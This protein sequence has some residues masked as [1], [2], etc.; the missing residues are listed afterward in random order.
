MIG[1]SSPENTAAMEVAAVEGRSLW[2]DARARLFRN[3]A[4]VVSMIVLSIF[5]LV[6]IFGPFFWPH[7]YE[8]IYTDRVS[9]APTFEHWHILGT[10]TLGRDQ[11][12][13]LLLGFRISL[14]VGVLATLVS[15]VIGVTWGAIAGYFGGRIDQAMMR[16]VDALYAIPFIF[17]VILLT[18]VFERNIFLI[19]LAIGAVEW[20]TM[21]RIVRGQTLTTKT[22][23]FIEAARAAGVSQ[24]AIIWR[25]IIP[26]IIGPVVIYITLIIPQVILLESFLSFIGLGINEPMTSL[27]VLLSLGKAQMSSKPWLLI[28]PA[29][30][31]MIT[32]LCLNFL[33]DGVRDAV[34]PKER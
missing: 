3:K 29:L 28:F 1:L 24:R 34:D 17:F 19:F 25:H 23:E 33:G 26:N 12:A 11:F 30:V 5:T 15:L 4:A 6:S 18:T 21:S 27:G 13:R 7:H 20:L 16:I 10:D 31:M 9:L 14:A 32:L 2:D 22:K 8:T